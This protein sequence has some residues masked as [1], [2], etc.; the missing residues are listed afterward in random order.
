[1]EHSS[2]MLG[3]RIVE[4]RIA[5]GGTGSGLVGSILLLSVL[6]AFACGGEQG[7]NEQTPSP[8]GQPAA[9]PATP[10]AGPEAPAPG[11]PIDEA[12]AA[13]GEQAFQARACVGC[14]L[15]GGGRL[16]GPDLQGVTE[17]RSYQWI[18]SMITNPDSMLRVDPTARQLLGEY[19]TPMVNMGVPAAEARALYEYLRRESQ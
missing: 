16:T 2:E 11:S 10:P 4:Y 12:L 6:V 14:H 19:G 17:R 8:G 5:R 3:D 15:I 7:S 18:M 13:R 9:A 1:M